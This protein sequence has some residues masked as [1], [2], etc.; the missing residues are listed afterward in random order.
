MCLSFRQKFKAKSVVTMSASSFYKAPG[1]KKFK[2]ET[3]NLQRNEPR[4]LLFGSRH[5]VL[6]ADQEC[7]VHEFL[8]A[9]EIGNLAFVSHGMKAFVEFALKNRKTMKCSTLTALNKA[10]GDAEQVGL[11]LIARCCSSLTHF[12]VLPGGGDTSEPIRRWVRAL[13]AANHTSL[14]VIDA[15]VKLDAQTLE[16]ITACRELERLDVSAR[17]FG[18][19]SELGIVGTKMPVRVA[20]RITLENLPHLQDLSISADVFIK[21]SMEAI[22]KEGN[23]LL[24]FFFFNSDAS[25]LL[26]AFL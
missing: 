8:D 23:L 19:F 14:R 24:A 15:H 20:Q 4:G 2:Y 26:Q 7:R 22:L 9:R 21:G 1:N 6:P 17:A 13:V 5:R 12:E 25:L 10:A 3:P 11:V 18:M 16:A